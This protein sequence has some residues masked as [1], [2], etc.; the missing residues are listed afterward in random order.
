MACNV[1]DQSEIGNLPANLVM[2]CAQG[3]T[4]SVTLTI[5]NPL[6][7]EGDGLPCD[8]TGW[9]IRGHVRKRREEA[10][11]VVASFYGSVLEQTTNR[12]KVRLSMP[13]SVT[14]AIPCGRTITALES[15]YVYDLEL[16]DSGGNVVGLIGGPFPVEPE[17]TR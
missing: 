10:S 6:P 15:R 9:D 8:L 13:A 7:P 4:L 2:K 1:C 12:G 11:P 14:G 16:Y 3:K 17:V 5:C